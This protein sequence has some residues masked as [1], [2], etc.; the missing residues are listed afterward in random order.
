M[1]QKFNVHKNQHVFYIFIIMVM[2]SCIS[3]STRIDGEIHSNGSAGLKLSS[4][5]LP[6]I[7]RLLKTLAVNGGSANEI[8]VLDAGLLNKAI[9]RITGVETAAL[10]NT[11]A[12]SVDGRIAISSLSIFL[13][14]LSGSLPVE[15]S[16]KRVPFAVLKQTDY[17]GN[18]T[19]TINRDTGRDFLSLISTELLDY[20]S[21]LMAPVATGEVISKTEYLELVASVY[22]RAIADELSQAKIS[23]SI[24]FP[25]PVENVR[26]GT[27]RGSRVEFIIHLLD[28]LVL[29]VPLVYEVFWTPWR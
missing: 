3:C 12:D 13:G 1:S 4:I 23:L 21:A 10:R 5:L 16:A 6:N 24:D 17:G 29:D 20:L 14:R 7:S 25:G 8:P 27:Y 2:A 18:L 15:N 28:I 11:A 9:A 19:V 22:G 26:G